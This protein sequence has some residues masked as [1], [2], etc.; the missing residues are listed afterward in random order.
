MRDRRL[1]PLPRLQYLQHR[2]EGRKELG[3]ILE[4]GV[5]PKTA[6]E[7]TRVQTAE[8]TATIAAPTIAGVAAPAAAVTTAATAVHTTTADPAAATT[9]ARPATDAAEAGTSKSK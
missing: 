5:P 3:G 9:R 4:Q 1:N 8:A 7:G 6:G 2:R